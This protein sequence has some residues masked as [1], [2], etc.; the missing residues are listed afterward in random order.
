[1]YALQQYS[2]VVGS[3]SENM[4]WFVYLYASMLRFHS[5]TIQC[6]MAFLLT[7]ELLTTK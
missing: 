6:F 5:L 1:M 7:E 2:S 3:L 4:P